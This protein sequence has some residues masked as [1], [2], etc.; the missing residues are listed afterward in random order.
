MKFHILIEDD[1][2][3]VLSKGCYNDADIAADSLVYFERINKEYKKDRKK[4]L[5]DLPF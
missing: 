2:G 4:E 5:D 3:K 1:N